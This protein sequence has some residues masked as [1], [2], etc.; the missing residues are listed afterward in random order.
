MSSLLFQL[1]DATAA[2]RPDWWRAGRPLAPRPREPRRGRSG[3]Y[4]RQ[5]Q[6]LHLIGRSGWAC[7][8]LAPLTTTRRWG[9]AIWAGHPH[10]GMPLCHSQ[11]ISADGF[12]LSLHYLRP[13]RHPCPSRGFIQLRTS[14]KVVV[15][16]L[17]I[18]YGNDRTDG[19]AAGGGGGG[20]FS[21][22]AGSVTFAWRRDVRARHHSNGAAR[23]SSELA[24]AKMVEWWS[25]LPYAQPR[26]VSIYS[27]SLRSPSHQYRFGRAAAA[28][29][30][31]IRVRR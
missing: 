16:S 5:I 10:A 23:A 21:S 13:C 22:A 14:A 11:S 4:C 20:R 25:A 28:R 24:A 9:R 7:P 26:E 3:Q 30:R 18:N 31:A 8:T 27:C 1:S 17:N 15:A 19:A 6:R 29:R 12:R 2:G